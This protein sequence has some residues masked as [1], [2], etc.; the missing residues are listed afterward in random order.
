[1]K[2]VDIE[3]L[4]DYSEINI[5]WIYFGDI[6]ELKLSLNLDNKN[7]GRC[8]LYILDKKNKSD[9]ELFYFFDEIEQVAVDNFIDIAEH[10]PKILS[11]MKTKRFVYLTNLYIDKEYRNKGIGSLFMNDVQNIIRFINIKEMYLVSD[12]YEDNNEPHRNESFYFKN[13]FKVIN[14]SKDDSYG[15]MMY[16]KI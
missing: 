2:K 11:N 14:D 8:S 5:Q 7:I 9:E 4:Y 1:M 13:K 15:K 6:V 10:N 3:E 12:T 16:K